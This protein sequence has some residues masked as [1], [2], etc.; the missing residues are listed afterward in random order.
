[1]RRLLIWVLVAFGIYM[2]VKLPATAASMVKAGVD[3]GG[4]LF[5]GAGAVLTG[6]FG[7]GGG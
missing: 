2:A 3:G 7:G 4:S 6:I 1:M 5:A